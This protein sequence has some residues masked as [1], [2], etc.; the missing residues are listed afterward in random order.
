VTAWSI[1][2]P[3]WWPALIAI[4]LIVG[5]VVWLQR[6]SQAALAADFGCRERDLLG[7]PVYRGA[8]AAL[9][10]A[11]LAAFTVALLRPVAPGRRA[12]LAPD[13][14][15]C[16]DVSRS[17]VAEDVA[18]SRFEVMR[19]QVRA[20]L[21]AAV[22]SRFAIVAFAGEAHLVAPLTS[23]RAAITWLLDELEPGAL[24][25][26]GTDLGAAIRS[27]QAALERLSAVGDLLL[28]TDGEDFGEEAAR[29]ASAARAAGHRVYGV[30]Y[31]S[32]AGS[33]I[34][35]EAEGGEQTFMVDGAGKDVVT[36]LNVA[37]LAA[38]S[39]A[40]GGELWRD[41]QRDALAIRWREELQPRAAQRQVASGDAD[42]VQR[43]TWPLL[44]GLLLWMLRMCLPERRR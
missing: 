11:A 3:S 41:A 32:P 39:E 31:G 26:G 29:A 25:P 37:G 20:L 44:G 7:R 22:G 28:L 16:V 42:V 34:V 15:L 40:G 5:F 36:R 19:Q 30:G 9:A 10:A 17:M 1:Q 33:K 23:D 2:P 8:R 6:R 21:D 27:S 43:F 13:V 18:P 35:I 24:G 12:Q 4:P 38:V 14:V